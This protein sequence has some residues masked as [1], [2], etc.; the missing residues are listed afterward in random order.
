MHQKSTSHSPE[1]N[2]NDES[3][4]KKTKKPF[5]LYLSLILILGIAVGIFSVFFFQNCSAM[6]HVKE[7]DNKRFEE[8]KKIHGR[9]T[10]I[11]QKVTSLLETNL[12]GKEVLDSTALRSII[13]ATVHYHTLADSILYQTKIYL[14][15]KDVDDIRQET[16]NVINKYNGLLSLWIAIITVI[17]GI[18]PWIV[19]FRIEERNN[20]LVAKIETD[21]EDDS[22]RVRE[23]IKEYKNMR[24]TSI[25]QFEYLKKDLSGKTEKIINKLQIEKDTICNDIDSIRN[26]YILEVDKNKII[27]VV[28]GITASAN[29][30]I[31]KCNNNRKELTR[32]FL[33]ELAF[34]LQ[35]FIQDLKKTNDVNPGSDFSKEALLVLFQIQFGIIKSQTIFTENHHNREMANLQETLKNVINDLLHASLLTSGIFKHLETVLAELHAFLLKI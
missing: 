32:L 5:F 12:K 35:S 6:N 9:D 1:M 30:S 2:N 22:K 28:F 23:E 10:V 34:N 25:Q 19:F 11:A 21:L 24:E 4:S 16:N 33:R 3:K 31:N 26:Q 17:G 27:N 14:L 18:V 13:D 20:Q 8:M 29:P 15:E 7:L